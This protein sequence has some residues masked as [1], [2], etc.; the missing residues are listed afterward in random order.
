MKSAHIP[1]IILCDGA[2]D[3][4]GWGVWVCVSVCVMG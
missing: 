2:F 1:L 4:G 3:V